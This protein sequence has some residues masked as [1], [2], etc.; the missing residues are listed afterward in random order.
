[1]IAALRGICPRCGNAPLFSGLAGFQPSCRACGLDYA[2]FNVGDGP[3]AFLIFIVGGI[4]V[5]L[6]IWLELRFAPPFWVHILLWVPLAA[7]LTVGLLRLGKGLLLALEYRN[8]ARE[9]RLRDTE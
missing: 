8:R 9:A 4:V 3:A 1:M 6:A 2:G 7:V 5:A